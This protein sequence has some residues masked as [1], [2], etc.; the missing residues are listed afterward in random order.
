MK[1][2]LFLLPIT[3]PALLAVPPQPVAAELAPM[4]VAIPDKDQLAAWVAD[5][6]HKD[7]ER[8]R[9]AADKLRLAGR[10]ARAVVPDLIEIVK[11]N[12]FQQP[13]AFAAEIL[14]SMG[15]AAK[16]AVPH[17]LAL[18]GRSGSG[19]NTDRIAVAISHIDGPHIEATRAVLMSHIRCTPILLPSSHYLATGPREIAQHLLE[20]CS[21]KDA[22]VRDRAVRVLAGME[23]DFRP[24][25]QE[26]AIMLWLGERTKEIPALL[27]KMLADDDV[28]VRLTVAQAI[29]YRAPQLSEKTIP[30][31]IAARSDRTVRAD[32]NTAV[33]TFRPVAHEA[34]KALIPLFDSKQEHLRTWA[35]ET[36][37]DLPVAAEVA[38]VLKDG[39]TARTR[40]AAAKCLSFRYSSVP[41]P[42]AALKAALTDSE[43]TVRHAAAL[44]LFQIGT[45]A[46]RIA[47]APVL[48]ESMKQDNEAVRLEAI[49]KLTLIG[50][51]A[52][53]AVPELKRLLANSK[54]EVAREAALALVRVVPKDAADAIPVLLRGLQ[55]SD[56][57]LSQS[58]RA[59]GELGPAAKIAVPEL[60]KK[61][62]ACQMPLRLELAQ[63]A[64]QIDPAYGSWVVDICI[65]VFR[66]PKT[67]GQHVRELA[68]DALVK[69]GPKAK[70]AMPALLEVMR[71]KG[72]HRME[73]ALAMIA[74][75]PANAE[76]ALAWAR[77]C[78]NEKNEHDDFRELLAQV[79][80][81]GPAAKPLLPE[82]MELLNSKTT[83][84]RQDAVI[85]IGRIGPDAKAALPRLKELAENDSLG[86]I[87]FHAD[88]AIKQIEAK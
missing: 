36:L 42:V 48:I 45:D 39:K 81:L 79:K 85:A 69:R 54:H 46:E 80:A 75:D 58:A 15:S 44:G 8:Q 50:V 13:P 16:D 1:S 71:E 68:A 60:L 9:L 67:R 2:L 86:R 7:Y 29:A 78:L 19:Y 11:G 62:E 77:K 43:F 65:A 56:S 87:Q 88:R 47:T 61:S 49:R 12:E 31:V 52:K 63:A 25:D 72:P 34:A 5:L 38:T 64:A 83:S 57:E 74:I 3:P 51:A 23:A 26:P 32:G 30:I 4:P 18:L 24:R 70:A 22:G 27:E 40:E 33:E 14:G 21:H 76:P 84:V 20:L 59:L 41:G 35:I 17:L 6:S 82:L 10:G 28:R 73:I 66:D 53:P 37:A 55:G